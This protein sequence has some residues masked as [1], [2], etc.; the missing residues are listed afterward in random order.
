VRRWSDGEMHIA[1]F[2]SRTQSYGPNRSGVDINAFY[3]VMARTAG[4]VSIFRTETR[5]L[6]R[7]QAYY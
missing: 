6:R 2:L 4:C 3:L 5:N 7:G 1:E